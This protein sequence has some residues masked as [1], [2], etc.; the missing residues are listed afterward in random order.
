MKNLTNGDQWTEGHAVIETPV[1]DRI[2]IPPPQ[3]LS[4]VFRECTHT[5]QVKHILLGNGRYLHG[6]SADGLLKIVY[7]LRYAIWSLEILPNT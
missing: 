6:T 3:P 1:F 2:Y 4:R 7:L 5:V